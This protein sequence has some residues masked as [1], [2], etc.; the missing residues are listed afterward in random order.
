MYLY[1]HAGLEPGYEYPS[2]EQFEVR[3]REDGKGKAVI[4]LTGHARGEM[5]ARFTGIMVPYR[6]QHSLQV[7]PGL[8]IIDLH[9][10]GYLAHSC[11]PNVF[12]D[13]QAF[14]VWALEDIEPETALTMDYAATEDELFKQFRCL[15]GANNCRHWI[16]GRKERISGEGL[17]YTQEVVQEQ[18]VASDE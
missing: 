18:E 7:N 10:V 4:T 5:I 14:E 16:T 17:F 1:P 3:D 13:M 12:V 2:V 8:H 9:F 6:T 11:A 15:C